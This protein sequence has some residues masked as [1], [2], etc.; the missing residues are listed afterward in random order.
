MVLYRVEITSAA[1][2]EIRVLP[3]KIRQRTLTLLKALSEEPRPNNSKPMDLS[4]LNYELPSGMELYRIRLESWR[5]VYVM[6]EEL[7]LLTILAVRK[8]P[9]YQYEDLRGLVEE[10]IATEEE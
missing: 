4:K 9:P 8:R 5:I 6:E 7:Q 2:K 3:G 1:R 10:A